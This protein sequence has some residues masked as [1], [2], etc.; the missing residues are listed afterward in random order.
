MFFFWGGA[1]STH[2]TPLITGLWGDLNSSGEGRWLKY[3][4]A[5]GRFGAV[6]N[7]DWI[8]THVSIF[9]AVLVTQVQISECMSGV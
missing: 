7:Y 8:Q 2:I 6:L 3:H 5:L 4:G 9:T 1:I